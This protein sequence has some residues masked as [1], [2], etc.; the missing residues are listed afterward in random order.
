MR[1]DGE[2]HPSPRRGEGWGEGLLSLRNRENPSPT[3]F[4]GH[5]SPMGRGITSRTLGRRRNLFRRSYPFVASAFSR[6]A[7]SVVVGVIASGSSFT[8]TMAGLPEAK[9]ASSAGRNAA[10]VSTVT[11]KPPKARA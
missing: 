5:L 8:C 4:A 6:S 10:S 1:M 11:P 9:A 3:R 7:E 2:P